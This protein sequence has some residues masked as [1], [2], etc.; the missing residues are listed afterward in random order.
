MYSKV[1]MHPV[2]FPDNFCPSEGLGTRMEHYQKFSTWK[3]EPWQ[4]YWSSPE[5]WPNKLRGENKT[6]SQHVAS[7][8]TWRETRLTGDPM[9]LSLD[10]TRTLMP[11]TQCN[12][13]QIKCRTG[14][15]E[16]P[17]LERVLRVVCLLGKTRVRR[18]PR[19]REDS[20]QRTDAGGRLRS[21]RA[22]RPEREQPLKQRKANR[23]MSRKEALRAH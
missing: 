11:W 17:G 9:V 7:N 20:W 1:T 5:H 2:I 6:N 16:G 23:T 10:L 8:R 3:L 4:R 12:T 22:D 19:E 21:E 18:L 13:E 14:G 15:W